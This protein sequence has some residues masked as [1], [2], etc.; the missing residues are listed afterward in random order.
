MEKFGMHILIGLIERRSGWRRETTL[1]LATWISP[2]PPGLEWGTTIFMDQVF[3]HFGIFPGASRTGDLGGWMHLWFATPVS[4]HA[5]SSEFCT[6]RTTGTS[7]TL[8]PLE[9]RLRRQTT[10]TLSCS[11]AAA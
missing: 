7:S 5:T 1:G 8:A 11:F 2:L 6:S 10:F 3:I 4:V 9:H